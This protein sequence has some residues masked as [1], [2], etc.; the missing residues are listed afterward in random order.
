MA[1]NVARHRV[2]WDLMMMVGCEEAGLLK[3]PGPPPAPG[4]WDWFENLS[5][6]KVIIVITVIHLQFLCAVGINRKHRFKENIFKK[7]IDTVVVSFWVRSTF[8]SSPAAPGEGPAQACGIAD[9]AGWGVGGSGYW[10]VSWGQ[11]KKGLEDGEAW[12]SAQWLL[13]CKRDEHF[14]CQP[15]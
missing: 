8:P 5:G 14:L 1:W 7:I 11:L 10:G 3:P 15:F 6:A 4:L 9:A 2:E 12:I 13:E